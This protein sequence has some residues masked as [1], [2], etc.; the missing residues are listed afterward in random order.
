VRFRPEDR[1]RPHVYSP[2]QAEFPGAGVNVPL[3]KLL[4]LSVSL[5]DNVAADIL[6]RLVG[7]PPAVNGYISSLGAGGFHLVDG[8]DALHR[9][10]AL[11]YRNWFEPAG[12]VQLLRRLSDHSPLTP[13]HTELLLGW[14]R[15]SPLSS[16]L[17][18]K[19]PP[20][21]SVAHK[22]GT[23]DVVNGW[24]AATNDIG[25]ITLPDGRT[26]AIAVFITDSTADGTTRDRTIA[27]IARAAY[28]AARRAR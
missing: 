3:R 7:G 27:R 21:T 14:M 15:A 24:A 16:R 13:E 28:D 10:P 18:G 6:L 19:L 11:Q 5:S 22:T 23:S 8:E 17:A 4:Q 12:A 2:L 9:D 25:L 1:I 26:L 20:G